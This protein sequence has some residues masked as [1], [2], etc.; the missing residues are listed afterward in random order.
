MWRRDVRDVAV[1]LGFAQ[2]WWKVRLRGAVPQW[3]AKQAGVNA[4]RH[5]GDATFVMSQCHWD[6]RGLGRKCVCLALR[7][8]G[9]R[10]TGWRKRGVSLVSGMICGIKSVPKECPARA[11][12]KSD[13]QE[14]P[15]RLSQI[16]CPT[17]VSV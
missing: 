15:T 3:S 11:S 1:P 10:E 4:A 7:A 16:E 9:E 17:R 13:P 14:C 6:L 12:Y 5:C 2:P 8:T